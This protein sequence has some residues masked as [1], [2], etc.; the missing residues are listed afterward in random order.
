[1]PP[2]LYNLF[3]RLAGRLDRWR[4]HAERARS[5][6]FNWIYLNPVTQPG[7]SGSLYAVRD[8]Y[9]VAA[10]FLPEGV[11]GDGTAE[12]ARLLEDFRALGL[13]TAIDLV[14]NHTAVDNPL[15]DLHPEWFV[16]DR[17]GRVVNPSAIDPADSRK[18]TVWGD[19]AEINNRRSKDR[20]GLWAYWQAL[21]RFYQDLGV[22]GFRCDAAYKVPA[23]LWKAL[24][25]E[26]NRGGRRMT[27]FAETLGC[28]E[29]EV[30]ALRGTGLDYLFNSSK[31]WA[32]DASWALD[33]HKL[34]GAVAPSVSFPESHDTPRLAAETRNNLAV[35]RQRYLLAA[36]FSEG[37]MMPI[38]YEF[39]FTRPLHVVQSRPEDWEETGVDLG[40][41]IRAVNRIKAESP[42]L[43]EEGRWVA[44][45]PYDRPTIALARSGRSGTWAILVNKDWHQSQPIEL[46]A[47]ELPVGTRLHRLDP[48][49]NLSQG[50]IPA[51]LQLV[52]AEI[53]WIA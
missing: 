51:A 35:L 2:I 36:L 16:R 11:T 48:E 25:A 13:S 20:A 41:F 49:G 29:R 28:R 43:G 46:G 50:P 8:Y 9:R 44:L 39:G 52:P 6:G 33:Q 21:V 53:A 14:I 15:T 4:V 17:R 31:Y 24:V 38:G 32:L 10:D 1:V 12:L 26:T 34:F 22:A 23:A 18:V 42:L 37:L 19:L 5:L 40:P 7:L 30:Q 3:P 27:F 45:T 47:L